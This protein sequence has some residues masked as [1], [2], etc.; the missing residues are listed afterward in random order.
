MSICIL[1]LFAFFSGHFAI[2]SGN[3]HK[4]VGFLTSDWYPADFRNYSLTF[5]SVFNC[6]WSN[7]SLTVN[8]RTKS[9]VDV[10]LKLS[11]EEE[12]NM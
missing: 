12:T 3:E 10:I 4:N 8:I 11:S 7:C 6:T 5:Y 9:S 2:L 1:I